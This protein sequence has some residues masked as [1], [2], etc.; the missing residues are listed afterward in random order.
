MIN[1]DFWKRIMLNWSRVKDLEN[2]EKIKQL[3]LLHAEQDNKIMSGYKMNVLDEE[4][5]DEW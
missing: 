1:K 5:D 2:I 3:A 4:D